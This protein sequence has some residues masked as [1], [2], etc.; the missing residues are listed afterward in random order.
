[1]DDVG[2]FRGLKVGDGL[3]RKLVHAGAGYGVG[4]LPGFVPHQGCGLEIR[5][6][7]LG[8]AVVGDGKGLG[9]GHVHPLQ[10]HGVGKG[11]VQ[12]KGGVLLGCNRGR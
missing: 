12:L 5:L 7:V 9:R 6:E 11:D 8:F 4:G 2:V 3:H 10:F 1:M